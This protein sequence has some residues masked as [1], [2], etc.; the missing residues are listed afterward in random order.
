M[1]S[2]PSTPSIKI[3]CHPIISCCVTRRNGEDL[4]RPQSSPRIHR[5]QQQDN[6][7]E[8]AHDTTCLHTAQASQ[9]EGLP[10][11]KLQN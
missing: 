8:M 4:L 11:E 3:K 2:T 1:G 10:N 6:P 9:K 5:C 7:T